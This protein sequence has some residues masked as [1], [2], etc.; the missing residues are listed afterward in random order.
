MFYINVNIPC[1]ELNFS[2]LQKDIETISLEFSLRDQRWLFI[3]SYRPNHNGNVF[4]DYLNKELTI[5]QVRYAKFR[6]LGD[7]N[8]TIEN[9]NLDLFMNVFSLESL[10]KTPSCF[11]ANNPSFPCSCIDLIISNRKEF[12]KKSCTVE[13]AIS[14]H[15]HLVVSVLKS[16]FIK[17]SKDYKKTDIEKFRAELYSNIDK[18]ELYLLF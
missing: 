11:K 8:M 1:R 7:F 13:V 15:H 18:K 16:E 17:V 2:I 3:A 14:D 9:K 4:L 12:F 5:P 10:I 6:L